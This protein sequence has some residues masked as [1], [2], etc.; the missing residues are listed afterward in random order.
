VKSNNKENTRREI[1]RKSRQN[2]SVT[3]KNE[4]YVNEEEINVE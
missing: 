4:K 3:N 2:T 1:G